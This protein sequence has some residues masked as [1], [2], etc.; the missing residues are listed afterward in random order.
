MKRPTILVTI[1]I[2]VVVLLL[3][4][5]IEVSCNSILRDS[6]IS[7]GLNCSFGAKDMVP[8][9]RELSSQ[10]PCYVSLPK[11][12]TSNQ[13]GEYDELPKETAGFLKELKLANSLTNIVGGCCGTTYEHIL[14]LYVNG[15]RTSTP[16]FYSLIPI[17]SIVSGLEIC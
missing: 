3:D 5:R 8:F 2:E 7:I 11:C 16:E 17:D 12:R 6:V 14:E 13:F 4:K 9:I 1:R 10:L 15:S